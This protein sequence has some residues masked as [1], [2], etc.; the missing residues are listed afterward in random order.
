MAGGISRRIY[1]VRLCLLE[2]K[3]RRKL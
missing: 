2:I 3:L 1:K